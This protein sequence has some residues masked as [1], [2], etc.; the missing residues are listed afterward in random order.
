M[1]LFSFLKNDGITSAVSNREADSI[2]IDVRE[3]DEFEAGHIPGAVNYPLSTLDKAALHWPKDAVLYLLSC[4]Y[5]KP[6][7][8]EVPAKSRIYKC[9][10]YWGY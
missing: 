10:K 3:K 2:L 5:Q 7:G 4:G 1:G 8:C 9:K 6:Q